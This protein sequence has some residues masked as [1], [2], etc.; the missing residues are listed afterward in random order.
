MEEEKTVAGERIVMLRV[1]TGGSV[2]SVEIAE[3][4]KIGE[5]EEEMTMI[6]RGIGEERRMIRRMK[7]GSVTRKREVDEVTTR[8]RKG[9]GRFGE[10]SEEGKQVMKERKGAEGRMIEMVTVQKEEEVMR[11][12]RSPLIVH[13]TTYVETETSGAPTIGMRFGIDQ[14]M[15]KEVGDQGTT[16][17]TMIAATNRRTKTGPAAT[18]VKRSRE[19]TTMRNG[20]ERM[21]IAIS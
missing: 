15:R 12:G 16:T 7:G 21:I 14:G 11:I 1:E 20:S 18:I 17:V 6:L 2:M 13:A 19:L 5:I 3:E 9:E 10:K 4:M 8:G